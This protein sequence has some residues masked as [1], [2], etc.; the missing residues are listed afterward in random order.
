MFPILILN[1]I[2]TLHLEVPY[3]IHLGPGGVTKMAVLV[4]LLFTLSFWA[5]EGSTW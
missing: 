5:C 1:Q 4:T 3:N 2:S